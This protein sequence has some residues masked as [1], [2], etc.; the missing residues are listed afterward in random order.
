MTPEP[1]SPPPV[2]DCARVIEF[3]VLN[4]TVGYRGR[5][6]LFVDGKEL[7][8]VPCLAIC[9]DNKPRGV[10]LFHCNREWTVLGCSAYGSIAEAKDRAEHIYPGL[11]PCWAN[12][13]VTEAQ[14]EQY[15]DEL[16]ADE[17]CSF[18]GKRADQVEQF[19]QR[20]QT[21]ICDHCIVEFHD[22][23]DKPSH[24]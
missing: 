5:T 4:E 18:C 8:Q 23:L 15:L 10:M 16:F 12:A 9:E 11:S 21:W 24:T 14:A 20:D 3:A 17:R 6:L 2:V 22:T 19:I 13:H 1:S 7:G